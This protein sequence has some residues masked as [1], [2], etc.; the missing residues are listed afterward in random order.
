[1]KCPSCDAILEVISSTKG[2]HSVTDFFQCNRC[3]RNWKYTVFIT[4]ALPGT[5]ATLSHSEMKE[6][7][8]VDIEL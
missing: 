3:G 8:A 5:V 7:D 2:E 6:I 4:P 1:M